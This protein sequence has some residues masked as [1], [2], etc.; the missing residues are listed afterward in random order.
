LISERGLCSRREADSWVR[1][2]RIK[3][4]GSIQSEP[5]TTVDPEVDHI[6]IDGRRLPV[7]PRLRYFMMFKPRGYLVTRSDPEGRRTVQDLMPGIRERLDPVG[8]LDLQTEGLL[9]F[10]NDGELA[11]RL[12]H[13]SGGLPRRYLAK[14][15]RMPT[16]K[17]LNRLRNG[18]QLEEGRSGPSTVRV[19][20]VTQTGNAWLEIIVKEGRN[21][22]V[23]RMLQ[24]VNHPVSKLRREGFGPLQL[25]DL[26]RGVAREL[27]HDELKL[28]RAAADGQGIASGHADGKPRRKAGWAKPKPK[29]RRGG[30]PRSKAI[31][32]RKRS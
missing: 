32:P 26:E 3:V 2:G 14:V 25:G 13:P 12:V 21:R 4:N 7:A 15:W 30:K 19:L 11:H 28:L 27:T 5:G 31:A 8:R 24:A 1:E 23:R 6:K 10:T 22:L 18:V 17:T 20:E 29:K 9:L 16:E